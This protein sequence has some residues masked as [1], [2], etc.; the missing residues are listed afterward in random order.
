MIDTF[1][2]DRRV[3]VTGHTGFMGGWLCALLVRAGARVTGYALAPPTKPSFAEATGIEDRID[4][5]IRADIRDLDT[6]TEAMIKAD[7]EVVFHLAAQ[8]L[9]LEA[10]D[11]PVET[12]ETNVMGTV[13]L[14]EAARRLGSLGALVMVTTD[15]VYKNENWHW[16]YREND[17]LGGREPYSASKAAS[18]FVIDAYRAS[19]LADVGV[20]AIRAGNIIGGGDWAENRLV[21]DAIRS[22]ASGRP[23]TLRHPGSTRPWQH[24]LDPLAGYM[25]LA[26]RLVAEPQVYSGGWNFGPAPKDCQPVSQ[27]ASL[28]AEN[29]GDG[30]EVVVEGASTV[31]EETFLS[32]DSAQA[33]ARL[34]W[35]PRWPLET[36]VKALSDWY[37]GWH[38]GADMWALTMAQIEDFETLGEH[39]GA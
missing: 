16:P 11:K 28:L 12:F 22:F 29:W 5:S 39:H 15:K 9:V 20:A 36:G 8:P 6:L 24:V 21:P 27:L 18:E 25:R 30:A 38:D 35:H 1:W 13:N 23:L 4:A 32:L 19:Y 7:P 17:R 33:H 26:A 3:F 10:Y 37:R 2:K 34:G 14:M 31:F